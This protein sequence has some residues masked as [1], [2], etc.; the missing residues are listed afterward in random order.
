MTSTEIINELKKLNNAALNDF[1]S[2]LGDPEEYHDGDP[3]TID[4]KT[5]EVINPTIEQDLSI[6]VNILHFVDYGIYIKIWGWTDSYGEPTEF[7]NFK[8]VQP[9]T[10]QL[11]VY[12]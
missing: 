5:V 4:W 8:E 1:T 6:E 10:K 7:D 12:E 9:V 11:T 2:Y 3:I